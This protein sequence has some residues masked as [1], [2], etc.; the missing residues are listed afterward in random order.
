LGLLSVYN[1]DGH[2]HH[3]TIGNRQSTL[4]DSSHSLRV[5]QDDLTKAR[6]MIFDS[7]RTEAAAV[8]NWVSHQS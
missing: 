2:G 6:S 8:G 4:C 3:D 1:R 5:S 7:T